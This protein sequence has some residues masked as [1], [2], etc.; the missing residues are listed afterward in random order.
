MT[1]PRFQRA[2][3]QWY[4]V[5][6]IGGVEETTTPGQVSAEGI[7]RVRSRVVGKAEV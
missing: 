7:Q 5:D 2:S 6:L 4:F 3:C 1:S